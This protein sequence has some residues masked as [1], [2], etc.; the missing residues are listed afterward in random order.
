MLSWDIALYCYVQRQFSAID[1]DANVGRAVLTSMQRAAN[2]VLLIGTE[3]FVCVV[4][5]R[6]GCVDVCL[7][8]WVGGR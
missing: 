7:S 3:V 8:A 2:V 1:L 4:C 5:A 6:F